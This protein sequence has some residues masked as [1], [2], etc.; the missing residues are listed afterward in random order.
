MTSLLSNIPFDNVFYYTWLVDFSFLDGNGKDIYN[1]K[2]DYVTNQAANNDRFLQKDIFIFWDTYST[3]DI[4]RLLDLYVYKQLH[5]R[6]YERV[7]DYFT[8]WLNHTINIS[9]TKVPELAAWCEK[10]NIS[11]GLETFNPLK[12]VSIRLIDANDNEFTQQMR[13]EEHF[14]VTEE[15]YSLLEAQITNQPSTTKQSVKSRNS[16]SIT[17]THL[18][19]YQTTQ[20]LGKDKTTLWRWK[21]DKY[22]IPIKVGRSNYYKREDI[23]AILDGKPSD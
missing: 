4:R 22:L 3:K 1:P 19:T 12:F 18:S 17:E 15:T 13:I 9:K 2:A 23:Q 7:G 14:G 16:N 8:E 5:K 20:M 10:F 21:K 11:N 6:G